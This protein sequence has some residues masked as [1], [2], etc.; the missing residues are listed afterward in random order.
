MTESKSVTV[1]NNTP[2]GNEIATPQVSLSDS[3][4]QTIE[5]IEE[6]RKN[7]RRF[8]DELTTRGVCHD[9]SKLESPE[10]ESFAEHDSTFPTLIYG[11][12]EYQRNL[13]SLKSTLDHHYAENRHHPEHFNEGIRDMTLI[14]IVEMFCDWQ[15]SAKRNKN[16]NLLN[17][18]EINAV[19]FHMD[20]LLK[21]IF[22]NTAKSIDKSE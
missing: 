8:T 13:A 18:I 7:I 21:Q 1:D 19:R 10:A 16:G 12:D 5:H 14:D 4:L 17:S 15:A 22:V 2:N 11:S 6:V 3:K 20:G 9:K